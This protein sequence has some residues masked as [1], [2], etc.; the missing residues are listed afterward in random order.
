MNKLPPHIENEIRKNPTA[1]L[2]SRGLVKPNAGGIDEVLIGIPN[3]AELYGEH[4]NLIREQ[5]VNREVIQPKEKENGSGTENSE[6]PTGEPLPV[7]ET[8]A[9][10]A[11]AAAQSEET[12]ESTGSGDVA[13]GQST[14]SQPEPTADT[15][16]QG[17]TKEAESPAAGELVD[18]SKKELEKEP[19]SVE[20]TAEEKEAAR[21]KA[22][23]D[24]AK[25]RHAAK[26][27][28]EAEAKKAAE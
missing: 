28:A 22:L 8:A 7:H 18:E 19:E 16:V 3:A 13:G 12:T 10:G 1:V 6:S 17:E 5:D 20:L 21:R 25:A 24:A 14:E 23:S 27:A 2:T 9:D 4:Y 26:K 11:A 15:A